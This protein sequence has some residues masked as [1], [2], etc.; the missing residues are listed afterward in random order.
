MQKL[1]INDYN[2]IKKYLEESNY[3][4]YNSNFVTMMMWDHEY[5][6]KYEIHENYL[7]MLQQYE[8][9]YYFA[10]PFCKKEYYQEAIDYM[11]GYATQHQFP[12]LIDCVIQE[13]RNEIMKIYGSKLVAI[14][15]PYNDDYVYTK[16]ALMTLSGKKMQKRRNHFNAFL[17]ENNN[18]IYKEIEDDDI[19]NVLACLKKWDNDHRNEESVQSEFI[20][21]IYLL[22]HREELNIKTGCIY[23]NNSLEAFIIGSPLQ[24]QTIQ[25]HVEKANKEIRGLYVAICKYFLENNYPTY[26]YVNREED[27]GIETLRQA[28]RSLHPY[29]MINK[30]CIQRKDFVISQASLQDTKAI[31]DL[32]KNNFPDEN[33]ETT[34]FYFSTCYNNENTFVLKIQNKVIS[35]IQIVPY[36]IQNRE[37]ID[38]VYFILGVSTIKEYQHNGCMK[39]L[40]NH[41]LS[42]EPFKQ[43]KI[44]LQAY[45][46]SIYYSFGFQEEYYHQRVIVDNNAYTSDLSV[47]SSSLANKQLVALYENYCKKYI[48]YRIRDEKY[49]QEYLLPRCKAFNDTLVGLYKNDYCLGYCIY[50]EGYD[51]IT[52][53]EIIY[54]DQASLDTIIKY[55][56][57]FNK[58]III[59]C[60]IYA[61]IAG[62]KEIVCTMMS[63]IINNDNQLL[64][65][66]EVL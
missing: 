45:M 35:A 23:I 21:I 17:K 8:N 10:M 11:L 66:N 7:I 19:D 34:D 60:D 48:G 2:K 26:L 54:L 33:E 63:N 51:S 59:E 57:S 13:V 22:M 16:E 38:T 47:T 25:I 36:S 49:Y 55:F 32:W 53:N 42:M 31:I 28:K 24:H 5:H 58:T 1:R 18:F 15:T 39:E 4:G 27:M 14:A 6:I 20:G 46:P 64:F 65:I 9:T 56:I 40:L 43:H 50:Q 29:K 61:N 37:S 52:I 12:F 41:I 62:Q 3:E 44:L 30:Y